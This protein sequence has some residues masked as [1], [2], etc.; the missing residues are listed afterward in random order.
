VAGPTDRGL[1]GAFTVL[2]AV[3]AALLAIAAPAADAKKKGGK[4]G[5]GVVN[6]TKVVNAP[7]PDAVEFGPEGVLTSTIDIGKRFKG[8][9][10]R[11]VNVTVQTVGLTG[12]T[13]GDDLVATLTAPNGATQPLFRN[14]FGTGAL[15]SVSIGP[16]TLDD[17]TPLDALGGQASAP[18][19]FLYNP[20]AGAAAPE[21]SLFAMDGGP[22]AGT[23]TLTVS[24]TADEE[25]SAL[26]PWRLNVVAG[27]P[28]LTK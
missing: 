14:L 2:V 8:K 19:L 21:G 22:V 15:P 10:I 12:T 16:L 1:R 5:G 6:V 20:W 11:D 27:R 18:T 26:S 23:W 13:P 17:E 24:D 28:F 3:F 25:T 4:K 7:I 9:R